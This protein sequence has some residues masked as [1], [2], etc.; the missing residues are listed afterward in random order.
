MALVP[1][2]SLARNA[3][4]FIQKINLLNKRHTTPQFNELW[5]PVDS[6]NK[7]FRTNMAN[8]HFH[9]SIYTYIS[10]CF[11]LLPKSASR[12]AFK[13]EHSIYVIYS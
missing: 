5:Y 2:K 9:Q 8:T 13:V 3:N 6:Q 11:F 10:K 12:K 7:T 4:L 1:G